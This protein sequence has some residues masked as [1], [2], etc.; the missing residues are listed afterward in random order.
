[1]LVELLQ[2]QRSGVGLEQVDHELAGARF[3][4]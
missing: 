3:P 1:M 2:G 4:H